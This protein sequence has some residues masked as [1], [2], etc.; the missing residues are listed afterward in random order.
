M[1]VS[2]QPCDESIVKVFVNSLDFSLVENGIQ[3]HSP[4]NTTRIESFWIPNSLLVVN[5]FKEQEVILKSDFCN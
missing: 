2:F 3:K 1:I 5:Q 4:D